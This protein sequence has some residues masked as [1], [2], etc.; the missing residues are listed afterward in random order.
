MPLMRLLL[1]I[2]FA[3]GLGT[4]ALHAEP[5]TL[6]RA[7][8]AALKDNPDAR[9]ATQRADAAEAMVEQAR[10][11]WYPQLSLQGRYT[12]TNSPMMAFGSILNQRAFNFGLDFNHPG[13]I[14][15]LNAS[16]TV[17]YN[18]YGGGR[19][20]AG[21]AAA[22]SGARAAAQEVRA[23]HNQLGAAVVKAYLDV[24]KARE[25]VGAIE[26]GVKAYEAGLA[27]AR[28]RSEAG[29]MLRA[30]LLSLEVQL[31]QTREQLASARHGAALA[32]RAFNFVLGT[33]N[34]GAPVEL[35]D[36]DPALSSLSVPATADFSGR[37]ELI[38]LQERVNAAEAMRRAARGSRQPTVNAFASYQYDQGWQLNRHGDSWLAGVS[39]D[40]NVFDGGQT[41]AKI[42]QSSSE[43]AQVKEMLRKTTLGIGLEVEQ[44]RLALADARERLA[45]TDQVVAQ[46][47]ESASLSRA[48]FDKGLLLIADLI[49]V[50]SRLIEVRMRHAFAVADER[51]AIADYRRALGLPLLSNN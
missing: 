40:L 22:H 31:A 47:E 13:Q 12:Q 4:A 44:A 51:I 14:D 9:L 25:A 36:A 17:A 15:N 39:L 33:E 3:V 45:V 30:D 19:P 27:A 7:V 49:G 6:D 38:G 37:P 23:A 28:I 16:A 48:R 42:R 50:E 2:L 21:L 1:P 11:A 35:A 43:L 8:A 32:E 18:I 10:S 26:A 29:Q 24:R 41:S 5:W 34:P 20:T 46:A